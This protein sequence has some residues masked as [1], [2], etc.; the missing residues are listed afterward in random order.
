MFYILRLEWLTTRAT[1]SRIGVVSSSLWRQ[2]DVNANP[3][4]PAI[5]SAVTCFCEPLMFLAVFVV[6]DRRVSVKT[7]GNVTVLQLVQLQYLRINLI[8]YICI[9]IEIR[10]TEFL[11]GLG[12]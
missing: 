10:L 8:S 1:E 11:Q 12:R 2:G 7:L 3:L 4:Y 6:Y 5:T 9:A